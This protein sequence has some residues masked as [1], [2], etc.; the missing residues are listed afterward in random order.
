M[1]GQLQI[2]CILPPNFKR[3]AETDKAVRNW[4]LLKREDIKGVFLAV[5][6][7]NATDGQ[8]AEMKLQ[9]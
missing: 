9:P 3:D 4:H 7:S 8:Y 5:R 6:D 1:I 2:L